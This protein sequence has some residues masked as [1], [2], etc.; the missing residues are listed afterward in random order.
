MKSEDVED[1]S[2]ILSG[3]DISREVAAKQ[4]GDDFSSIPDPTLGL[5][6]YPQGLYSLNIL[7]TVIC[8]VPIFFLNI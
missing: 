8:V 2:K 1:F 7:T 6:V 3:D 5:A 4:F